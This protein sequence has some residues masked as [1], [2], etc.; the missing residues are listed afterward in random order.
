[1]PM[2]EPFPGLSELLTSMGR[3]GQRLAA[4]SASE[5]AAGNISAC[6]GWPIE[7]RRRF[8]LSE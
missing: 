4:M 8:P 1:M 3:A 5:G 2:T 7:V 6:I